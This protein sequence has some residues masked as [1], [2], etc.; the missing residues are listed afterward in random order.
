MLEAILSFLPR[1]IAQG[2][3][4]LYG[5]TGEIIT[6]K[7]GNLNL[8][9][10][11]MMYMGG[12][13]GLI[14][15]FLYEN[16]VA[17][18]IPVVGMLIALYERAVAAYAELIH[19]NAFHQPGVQAGKLAANGFLKLLAAA[20]AALTTE[21]A[22]AADIAAKVSADEED[23]YHALVHI[24]ESGKASW[25]MGDCPCCDTFAL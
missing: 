6:Q 8:G 22:T 13:A 12:V 11:G 9:V 24:A 16:N 3:P 4:L 18:P 10:P 23:T 14:G 20:E 2:T 15:A 25:T 7:S 1:A 5:S 19:I 17:A 21:P